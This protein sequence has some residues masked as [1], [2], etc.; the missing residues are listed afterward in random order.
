MRWQRDDA[1]HRRSFDADL[2]RIAF[3][4]IDETCG[5]R[6]VLKCVQCILKYGKFIE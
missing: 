3:T 5:K 4:L 1:V 2:K 6:C